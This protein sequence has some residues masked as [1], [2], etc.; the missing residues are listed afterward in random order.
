M[1]TQNLFPLS[2]AARR[3]PNRKGGRGVSPPTPWRWAMK[4]VKGIRLESWMI[5]GIRMTSDEALERFFIAVTAAAN[6]APV[7]ARTPAARQR[8]IEAADAELS[9]AGI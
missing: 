5:G 6:G 7:Q 4:G 9:A 1:L 2:V 3:V 8:A